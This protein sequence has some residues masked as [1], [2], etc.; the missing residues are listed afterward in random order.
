MKQPISDLKSGLVNF[1]PTKNDFLYKFFTRLLRTDPIPPV[2]AGVVYFLLS[3]GGTILLGYFT[4]FLFGRNSQLAPISTDYMNIINVGIIAPIGAGLLINLYNK[5]KVAFIDLKSNK[6]IMNNFSEYDT[7]LNKLLNLYSRK[8]VVYSALIISILLNIFFMFKKS[9]EWSGIYGGITAIYFRLFVV[10]NYYMILIISYKCIITTWAIREIFKFNLIVQPLH[11]D[12]CGGLKVIGS[13]SI[14]MHYFLQ[15]I[16]LFL[17]MIVIF[18]SGSL[19]NIVFILTFLSL[20]IVTIFSLFF[21]L[22]KAHSK[23]QS[24]KDNLLIKLHLEFRKNYDQLLNDEFK[25]D[26]ANNLQ[27]IH[28]L[29]ALAEKMPVWPFDI[30]SIIRFF[31]AIS[32]PIF[33][34]LVEM[35]SNTDS[36]IYNLERLNIFKHF[37][38]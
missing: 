25:K 14:A 1:D 23:M 13:L 6:I 37:M 20:V 19:H 32:I 17:T 5:M 35:L 38:K 10:I 30:H 8:E 4:D 16:I 22:Y 18:N 9:N 11:P 27:S 36:I 3:S 7:L 34:F 29:Y 2:L 33:I 31:S 15:L 28:N 26:I 12:K 21:S 24:A